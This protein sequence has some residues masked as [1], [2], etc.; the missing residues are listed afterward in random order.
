M[1][2]ETFDENVFTVFLAPTDDLLFKLA[3]VFTFIGAKQLYRFR[4][5]EK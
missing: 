4:R 1:R 3:R 2:K 5:M